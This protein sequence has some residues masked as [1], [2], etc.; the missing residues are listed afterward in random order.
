[1]VE[2]SR[3][4]AAPRGPPPAIDPAQNV[5]VRTGG[6]GAHALVHAQEERAGSTATVPEEVAAEHLWLFSL[7]TL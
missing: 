6:P 1:M 5:G 7:P 3:R 4:W 2:R